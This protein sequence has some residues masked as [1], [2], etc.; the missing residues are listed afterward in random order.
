MVMD[1]PSSFIPHQHHSV[2][3]MKNASIFHIISQ[4]FLLFLTGVGCGVVWCDVM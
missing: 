4:A 1:T 3:I 2:G